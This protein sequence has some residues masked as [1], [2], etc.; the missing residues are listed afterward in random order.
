[1]KR[2][3]KAREIA[4]VLLPALGLG[5]FAWYQ[6]RVE[7]VSSPQ[8]NELFVSSVAV[9]PNSAY[10]VF[11]GR[12]HTL[13]VSITHPWPR[14]KWWGRGYESNSVLN[15]LAP[16]PQ[17]S[18][19]NPYPLMRRD[20]FA[21]LA[22]GGALTYQSNGQRKRIA[23]AQKTHYSGYG[24]WGNG[25]CVF[26]HSL[27]LEKVPMSYGALTFHG[28][29]FVN[30]QGP[31]RITRVVRAAG[32]HLVFNHSRN[33]NGS[34][35][36][37]RAAPFEA[38]FYTKPPVDQCVVTVR[39]SHPAR[40]DGKPTDLSLSDSYVELLDATRNV[41][42]FDQTKVTLAW[43]GDD[44]KFPNTPTQ[45]ARVMMVEIDRTLAL[46]QPL[47]LHGKAFINGG[48]PIPFSVKLPPR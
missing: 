14:P 27:D 46:R 35:I 15:P 37:A 21:F 28:I 30:G 1:M 11:E 7:Q 5:G 47:T 2:P 34:L 32:E 13:T 40:A 26:T 29:Y 24:Q 45:S 41:V 48:W 16:H 17:P 10:S 38:L 12:S 19:N 25:D 44:D 33:T 20:Q 4:F 23:L 36:F 39:F 42:K 6:W 9:T 31:V 3:L 18:Q 22:S 43:R 8:S